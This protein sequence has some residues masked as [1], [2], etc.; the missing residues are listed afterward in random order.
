MESHAEPGT[1]QLTQRTAERL[2]ER[3][4]L[5]PRGTIE[6][7]GKGAMSTYLFI[8]PRDEKETA[9]GARELRAPHNHDEEMVRI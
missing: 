4:E 1:I 7:N 6:I 2:R 3:Y 8:A 9:A 5:R